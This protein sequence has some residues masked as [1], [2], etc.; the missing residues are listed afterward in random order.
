MAIRKLCDAT[1][2]L[3]TVTSQSEAAPFKFWLLPSF[4]LFFQL[5]HYEFR[6]HR[7]PTSSSMWIKV[8][9]CYG[10]TIIYQMNMMLRYKGLSNERV[11][12][13]RSQIK[14]E[15]GQFS[16]RPCRPVFQTEN[17]IHFII[18]HLKNKLKAY[19]GPVLWSVDFHLF[20]SPMFQ[21]SLQGPD[22]GCS[23]VKL[24]F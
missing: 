14:W 18:Q 3:P 4:C 8:G 11:R 15:V 12:S 17:W 10:P 16:Y 5:R 6:R 24:A 22:A 19:R 20:A 9:P 23:L 21:L 2:T 13:M 7:W 1:V